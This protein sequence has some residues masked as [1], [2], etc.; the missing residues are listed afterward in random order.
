MP[1]GVEG[2]RG[3]FL[4]DWLARLRASLMRLIIRCALPTRAWRGAPFG[5]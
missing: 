2:R 1:V 5:N 4:S 3:R